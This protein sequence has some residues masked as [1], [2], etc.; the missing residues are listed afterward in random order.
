MGVGL[1]INFEWYVTFRG[2]SVFETNTYVKPEEPVE[3]AD[4]IC[5]IDSSGDAISVSAN[6]LL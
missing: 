5:L 6:L 4:D 1:V 2:N 3:I